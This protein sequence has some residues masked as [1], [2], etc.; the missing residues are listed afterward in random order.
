MM[1]KSATVADFGGMG[2]GFWVWEKGG[3]AAPPYLMVH[4][5]SPLPHGYSFSSNALERL[6]KFVMLP[7]NKIVQK[8]E[9]IVCGS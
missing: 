3:G 9:F 8:S 5:N 1:G 6:G 4:Q 2:S 7:R